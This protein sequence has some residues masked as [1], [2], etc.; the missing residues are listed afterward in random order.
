[1][2]V[3]IEYLKLSEDLGPV[4]FYIWGAVALAYLY[5]QLGYASRVGVKQIVG[6]LPVLEV[7]LN[8]LYE[9]FS[10]DYLNIIY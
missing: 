4:S 1:M 8:S 7:L 3:S 5:R 6:Y 9:Y 2:R 10:N